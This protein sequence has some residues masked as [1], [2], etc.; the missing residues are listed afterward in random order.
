MKISTIIPA[1]DE[2]LV[3][4]IAE[5]QTEEPWEMTQEK[6][7]ADQLVKNKYKTQYLRNQKAFLI[8]KEQ[9]AKKWRQKLNE[10]A[11]IG[12]ISDKIL[13]NFEELYGSPAQEFRG[14]KEK[15]IL[16]WIPRDI[17]NKEIHKKL[18]RTV[19][20]KLI[21]ERTWQEQRKIVANDQTRKLTKAEWK[22]ERN[23]YDIA[24]RKAFREGKNIPNN[25]L[26]EC[27]EFF[28]GVI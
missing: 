26:K 11:E 22:A 7:I 12:R 17:R 23:S 8:F 15:G 5:A 3:G 6:Y 27:K 25:I 9:T 21:Y 4:H 1:V 19:I 10:K 24:I 20:N 18:L 16:G 2:C 14:I 28:K 13:D